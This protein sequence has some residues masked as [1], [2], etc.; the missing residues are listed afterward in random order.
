MYLE[1]IIFDNRA[2][3]EHL[4][5]DFK[6]K[7][8]NVL[9]AI[10]G[11]GKTTILSHIADAF[12]E[13]ARPA[14]PREF[15]GKET[16]LYR[17][18]SPNYDLN[19]NK[20]SIVYLRFRDGEEILDYI[21]ITGKCSKEEYDKIIKIENKIDYN[22][23][24]DEL[25]DQNFIRFWPFDRDNWPINRK[26]HKKAKKIFYSNLL[27]FFP[28]YRF[29]IPA[30]LNNVYSK[31]LEYS[32]KNSFN[33]Y[34]TNPLE[35]VSD[36]S[37]LANWFLDVLLD[38]KIN[39]TTQFPTQ[40]DSVLKNMNIILSSALSSKKYKGVIRFGI[41]RRN[42][43]A[44]R[45]AIMNDIENRSVLICPSIFQLS[46]GELAL[47]SIF[48]EILRQA[49]NNRN[50][51][52]LTEIQGIVLI[53][54]IDKHLHITLQ[55]EILPK[56]FELFPKIQFIVSSHSPFFNM[57]LAE[58]LPENH[59]IFDLDNNGIS[60]SATKNEQYEEVFQMMIGEN[61]RYANLYNDLKDKLT[62]LSKPLVITEG[63]TDVIHLKAALQK[64]NI[65][66]IDVEFYE[67]KED[68]GDSKL[69]NLLENLAKVRQ[70][71]RIIGIFDRDNE[72]DTFIKFTTTDSTQY[73]EIGIEGSNVYG[74]CI[75]SLENDRYNNEIKISIEHYYKKENLQQETKEKRRIFLGEE[76]YESGNSKDGKY[77]TKISQIQNKIK[78]NG[79]IDDKVFERDDLEQKNNIALTKNDFANLVL[80][81]SEFAKDFDF[82]D[83]KKIFSLIKEIIELPN[84]EIL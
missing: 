18:S 60:C 77:Q 53:D 8:V 39:G 3:F 20:T 76:F 65:T 34:L 52:Q 71:R 35:V 38:F 42:S 43:G 78:V 14:F 2:P 7:G 23:F 50:N 36:I 84:K 6:D 83:F 67:I 25:N 57:G 27:T 15:E 44:T 74:F 73:K 54:E 21:D 55:K 13:L 46:S 22:S 64:L 75:P 16:K 26:K 12:Y 33:G 40:E 61:E 62:T 81:D 45:I 10:N 80:N 31:P 49:D 30:Y 68:W 47:L 82:S 51:I 4:E 1:K 41:G 48:G 17:V 69:K 70:S 72:K 24:S 63:K 37:S 79:I 28:S 66:D 5:I 19:P 29:E 9:T 58:R 32:I 11:K 59:M 56:M